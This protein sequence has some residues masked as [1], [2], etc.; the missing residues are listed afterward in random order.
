MRKESDED[1]LAYLQSKKTKDMGFAMLMERYKERIYWYI[2]RTV[3][4]HEDAEDVLQECFIKVYQHVGKFKGNSKLY[5]WIYRIATNE[6][7]KLFRSRKISF[8]DNKEIDTVL[9]SRLQYEMCNEEEIVL[10]FKEAVLR[11]PKQQQA[12]FNLRYYDDLSYEEIAQI[13]DSSVGTLKTN[14]HYAVEKVKNYLLEQ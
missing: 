13:I 4:S 2:R 12:V 11:L 1:I 5:T 8:V 6:C 14:Y 10:K 9:I 3:V 7:I